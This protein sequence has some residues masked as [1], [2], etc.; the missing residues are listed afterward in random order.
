MITLAELID[1]YEPELLNAYA[2]Q[3]LPGHKRALAAMKLCRTDNSPMM[4]TQCLAC[5]DKGMLPHSCGHRSCP[6][7]QHHESQ[8]WLERQQRKLLPVNY[9]MITFTLPAQMRSLAWHHQQA[10]YDLLFKVSWE[11]LACFGL[12]DKQLKGKLGATGVL[13]THSRKLD[14]HPHL[15][16]IVPAGALD[17]TNRLW[18]KKRGKYLFNQKNLSKV[19]RAKWFQALKE[20]G[21]KVKDNLPKDWI[22]DCRHIG[23]GNKAL[24]Y[25]GK[26][27][28]RGV[29]SEKNILSIKDGK[30]TFRYTDN[31]GATKT[32]TLA[33]AD[34]LWLLLRHVLPKGFRR[35]R[36]YGYLHANSKSLIQLIQLLL[37][38]VLQTA[39]ERL[40]AVIHCKQCG[41]P[42]AIVA[43]RI[44]AQE[45][46][47]FITS[48]G[49]T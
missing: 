43:T 14:Y 44:S 25:L 18:G 31:T 48:T 4:M 17:R 45:R 46:A 24:I 1:R 29:L 35:A 27:L 20:H 33:G 6:H 10:I 15:H 23:S 7:C 34:F 3:L 32:R 30:V 9:F 38:V 42:M 37:H 49:T 19:F 21:F 40:R 28:Y 13:H 26:Y 12:N 5:E 16:M 39:K 22:V 8:R 36:D 11:T 2:E 47:R 41:G